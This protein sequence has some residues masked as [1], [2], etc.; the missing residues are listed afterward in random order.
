MFAL[1]V[2]VLTAALAAQASDF[3]GDQGVCRKLPF[4]RHLY[5]NLESLVAQAD[6]HANTCVRTKGRLRLHG[7]AQEQ[8]DALRGPWMLTLEDPESGESVSVSP[9]AE[10]SEQFNEYALSLV[11]RGIEVAGRFIVGPPHWISFSGYEVTPV[12]TVRRPDEILSACDVAG[13]PDVYLGQTIVVWAPY[14]GRNVFRDLPDEGRPDGTAWVVGDEDCAVWITGHSPSGKGFILEVPPR[15][16]RWLK[17][18]GKLERRGGAL[19]VKASK[20]TLS[21]PRD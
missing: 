16:A 10:I 17:I 2:P 11:G 7:R 20:V 14:R 3:T 1:T 19:V 4:A 5:V 15:E 13:S 8:G 9:R 18:E 21:M 6:V 12:G